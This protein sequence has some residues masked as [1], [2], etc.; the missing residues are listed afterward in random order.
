MAK[1]GPWHKIGS[2]YDNF[3]H[4]SS[5][6]YK[7]SN[8]H[9]F[10]FLNVKGLKLGHTQHAV[11]F[12]DINS[13]SCNDNFMKSCCAYKGLFVWFVHLGVLRAF[14]AWI[15]KSE[16]FLTLYVEYFVCSSQGQI[17]VHS[18]IVCGVPF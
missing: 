18:D 8:H 17:H 13:L 16:M 2:W 6:F 12:P 5:L 9:K 10:S 7:N 1:L 3:V 4:K 15:K 14:C 11:S